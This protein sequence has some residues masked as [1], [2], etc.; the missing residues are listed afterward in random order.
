MLRDPPRRSV[1]AHRCG[2]GRFM[3]VRRSSGVSGD[4]DPNRF[5]EPRTPPQVPAADFK[6]HP[7]TRL[8]CILRCI[9]QNPAIS[10][11]KPGVLLVP[12]R[13]W[14]ERSPLRRRPLVRITL[15]RAV[16]TA[17]KQLRRLPSSGGAQPRCFS[18]L[19]DLRASACA[20]Q[21]CSGISSDAE[22]GVLSRP[23]RSRSPVVASG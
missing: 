7:D 4:G 19:S 6:I 13:P 11:R 18:G 5:A 20:R 17:P 15:E 12:L 8:R 10:A 21:V 9:R 1:T 2:S 16:A 22:T 14:F 23:L 3:R